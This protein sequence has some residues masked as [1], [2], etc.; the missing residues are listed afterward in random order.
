MPA[1][2]RIGAAALSALGFGSSTAA[3]V[4]A[5]YLIVAGGGGSGSYAG[6]CGAGGLQ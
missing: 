6:G 2:K 3:T 4:T 1:L 5:N